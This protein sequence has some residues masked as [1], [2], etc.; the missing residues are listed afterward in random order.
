MVFLR[1]GKMVEGR[2]K[3]TISDDAQIHINTI[4]QHN[5]RFG[6]AFASNGLEPG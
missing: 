6:W 5:A 3:V 4:G 1:A 2:G